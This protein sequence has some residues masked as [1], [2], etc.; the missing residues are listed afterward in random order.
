MNYLLDL[1]VIIFIALLTF[2]G[3]K[4]GLI[5]V[6][7]KIISFVLAI[8]ISFLVYKP[9][10]NII[11]KNTS[12]QQKIESSISEKLSTSETAKEETS[13]LLS[14]YYKAGKNATVSIIS[15]DVATIIINIS[16]VLIVFVLSRIILG[17]FKFSGDIIAKLPLIKQINH[18]GGFVYGLT[19]G[20]LIVYAVFAI[21]SITAPLVNLNSFINLINASIISNIMYNNN[22]ILMLLV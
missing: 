20:F 22:V 11:I 1:V 8:F 13:N 5:K 17:L 4:K 3:T 16:V 18:L 15:R 10:S 2:L 9:V 21:I 19:K 7:F 12:L 14:N 6:T